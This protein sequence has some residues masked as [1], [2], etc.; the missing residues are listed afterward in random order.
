MNYDE[1]WHQATCK[2]AK[3]MIFACLA[4]MN[5]GLH[6]YFPNICFDKGETEGKAERCSRFATRK[7]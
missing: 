5:I 1:Q 2:N 4:I 3:K 7:Y 6:L